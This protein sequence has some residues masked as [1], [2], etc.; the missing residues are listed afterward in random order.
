M[1]AAVQ[2]REISR[3][4]MAKAIARLENKVAS[5]N[6]MTTVVMKCFQI[7]VHKN[8]I[9]TQEFNNAFN[10]AASEMQLIIDPNLIKRSPVQPEDSGSDEASVG[11]SEAGI[12]RDPST[13]TD[14]RGNETAR[15]GEN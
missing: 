9:S 5:L 3:K 8:L 12:L 6:N 2:M 14:E 11:D 4:D 7:L 1:Q 13:G 15:D 10:E